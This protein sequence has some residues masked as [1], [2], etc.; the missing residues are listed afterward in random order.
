MA[1]LLTQVLPR[2]RQQAHRVGQ[3]ALGERPLWP[4][5]RSFPGKTD[6]RVF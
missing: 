4:E 2:R 6:V 3:R 1:A 5:C